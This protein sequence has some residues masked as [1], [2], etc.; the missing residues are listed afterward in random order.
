MADKQ[1]VSAY[2]IEES[3]EPT[4]LLLGTKIRNG[5]NTTVNFQIQDIASSGNIPEGNVPTTPTDAC[6][7]G[8]IGLDANYVYFATAS[9]AWRRAPVS[10]WPTGLAYTIANL[11]GARALDLNTDYTIDDLA[12]LL[13]QLIT[14]LKTAKVLE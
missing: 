14:D 5:V 2:D 9:G 6:D 4:D 12:E 3:P 8:E 1:T 10:A 11:T 13:G 7:F